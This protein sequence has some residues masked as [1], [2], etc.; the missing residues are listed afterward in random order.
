MNL[1]SMILLLA[2]AAADGPPAQ[3]PASICNEMTI[4]LAD[5]SIDNAGATV[6]VA[7]QLHSGDCA[8]LPNLPAGAYAIHF[9]ERGRQQSALCVQGVSLRPGKTIKIAPDDDARCVF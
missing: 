3:P 8:I 9:T 7:A 5:V 2:W 6:A 1:A 4:E